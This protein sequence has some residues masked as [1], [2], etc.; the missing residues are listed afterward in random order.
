MKIKFKSDLGKKGY[1]QIDFTFAVFI[2]FTF[3]LSVYGLYDYKLNSYDDTMKIN[4]LNSKSR[5]IC[6]L[7]AYTPGIPT[8][9]E[10]S[11]PSTNLIGLKVNGLNHTIDSSKLS[12]LNSTDFF[13]IQSILNIT[14]FYR[15]SIKG[16]ETN[17]SYLDYGTASSLDA[18]YSTYTCYSNLN[19][20]VVSIVVEIWK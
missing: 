3:F 8:N 20:E 11:V 18:L 5:D 16:L 15:I 7:L 19:A 14:D 4:S 1:V 6:Y 17:T 2:F 9:W 12:S 10:S 13:T